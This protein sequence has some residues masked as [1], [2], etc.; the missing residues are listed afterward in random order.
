MAL[1]ADWVSASSPARRAWSCTQRRCKARPIWSHRAWAW[2]RWSGDSMV[3]PRPRNVDGTERGVAATQGAGRGRARR[4]GGS[5]RG[6]AGGHRRRTAASPRARWRRA[7]RAPR[8]TRRRQVAAAPRPAARPGSTAPATA[9]RHGLA[10]C[11]RRASGRRTRA[12]RA[13]AGPHAAPRAGPSQA[14]RSCQPSQASA[15]SEPTAIQGRNWT[16][17]RE[18]MG[19]AV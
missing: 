15:I 19:G 8:P 17:G 6:P 2:A 16:M 14:R 10:A 18:T 9:A 12:A 1:R 4:H 11:P 13:P 5:C 7:R 3:L